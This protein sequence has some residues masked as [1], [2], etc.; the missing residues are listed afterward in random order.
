MYQIDIRYACENWKYQE[1]EVN[2]PTIADAL[3]LAYRAVKDFLHI[4]KPDF[5]TIGNWEFLVW[6]NGGPAAYVG[7][8]DLDKDQKSAITGRSFPYLPKAN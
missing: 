8:F 6:H 5:L 4:D 2:T 7:I 1:W 3:Y